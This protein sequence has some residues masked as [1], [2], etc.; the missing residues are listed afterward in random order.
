MLLGKCPHSF[1]R[2]DLAGLIHRVAMIKGVALLTVCDLDC[3]IV[4][5]IPPNV[6]SYAW[7][8]IDGGSD[9]AGV[10]KRL[11]RRLV[12][13]SFQKGSHTVDHRPNDLVG[14]ASKSQNRCN[15]DNGRGAPDRLV[16]GVFG[17]EVWDLDELK[18][19]TFRRCLEHILVQ[20]CRI[21]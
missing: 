13:R 18:K 10:D 17:T 20:P 3:A 14:I 15:M 1:L 8:V 21:M 12:K 19:A 4:P 2:F 5:R 7:M 9:G 16:E 11:H 6:G